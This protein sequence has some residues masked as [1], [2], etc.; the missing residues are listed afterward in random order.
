VILRI[1]IEPGPRPRTRT[2]TRTP[3]CV[4]SF[5]L[6]D[7]SSSKKLDPREYLGGV[8]PTLLTALSQLAAQQPAE[9]YKW[10]SQYFQQVHNAKATFTPVRLVDSPPPQQQHSGVQ[11]AGSGSRAGSS[12]SLSNSPRQ[13]PGSSGFSTAAS[14]SASLVGGGGGGHAAGSAVKAVRGA[15][16]LN[17]MSSLSLT[18]L[19]AEV[20]SETDF[21]AGTGGV[22]SL[23]AYIA[24][25]HAHSKRFL[26]SPKGEGGANGGDNDDH[27]WAVTDLPHPFTSHHGMWDG[28][29]LVKAFVAFQKQ[30]YILGK[31]SVI[32]VE[33]CVR[34]CVCACVRDSCLPQYY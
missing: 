7:M 21:I 2:R 25:P 20:V 18:D 32:V 4:F 26:V 5:D 8:Y 1:V 22:E 30:L 29:G 12:N 3:V 9:P 28:F 23:G 13:S 31:S 10:L 11:R 17:N 15:G 24:D 16:A 34:A 6:D 33:A 27:L 19:G 14:S